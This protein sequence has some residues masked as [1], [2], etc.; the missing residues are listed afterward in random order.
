MWVADEIVDDGEVNL[1][2]SHVV[3]WDEREEGMRTG[4]VMGQYMYFAVAAC[5]HHHFPAFLIR[6]C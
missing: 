4:L 1:L 3:D 5:C 2:G 6:A